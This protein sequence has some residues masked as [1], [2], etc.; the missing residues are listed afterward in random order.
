MHLTPYD[1]NWP[2][3]P[4]D[5]AVPPNGD[6]PNPKGGDPE[7]DPCTGDGSIIECQ[8]QILGE[9]IPIIGTPFSLNYRSDRVPG[10]EGAYT[11]EIPLTGDGVPGSLRAVIMEIHVAGR[12]IKERVEYPSPNYVYTFTWDGLD[13]YRR[14]MQ[15]AQPIAI[16]I[17]F[18]YPAM[19]YPVPS[20]LNN[21]FDRVQE[22]REPQVVQAQFPL[23][24]VQAY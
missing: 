5:D 21:A 17:Q 6:N 8:N 9:R 1:C 24:H 11:V 3:G 12:I 13:V 23:S 18:E 2:Y 22:H 15:G 4:P 16:S 10:P 7:D 14:K 20:S 19:Y